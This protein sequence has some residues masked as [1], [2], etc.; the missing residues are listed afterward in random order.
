M[1][2]EASNQLCVAEQRLAKLKNEHSM[3]VED[4]TEPREG[5]DRADPREAEDR[6]K[7]GEG[8][9][10]AKP[11]EGE[12]RAKPGEGE[13][14]AEPR[15]GEDRAEPR[16]GE[17]AADDKGKR[18]ETRDPSTR[19]KTMDI[20][21]LI[22]AFFD[23]VTDSNKVL[24]KERQAGDGKTTK[25]SEVILK[26]L[27]TEI[28][29]FAV[30][31]RMLDD[32][33]ITTTDKN[34][35]QIDEKDEGEA[36][37][38]EV[39]TQIQDTK[40]TIER[41][42]A[43]MD[44]VTPLLPLLLRQIGSEKS[45]EMKEKAIS[46]KQTSDSVMSLLDTGIPAL[47]EEDVM[48]GVKATATAASTHS[49]LVLI[50]EQ[51]SQMKL[52]EIAHFGKNKGWAK[53]RA[54]R[55]LLG[56]KLGGKLGGEP[57][58]QGGL[59][60]IHELRQS[61]LRAHLQ[62]CLEASRKLVTGAGLPR[63]FPQAGDRAVG[64]ALCQDEQKE[65]EVYE[66]LAQEI[67]E[68]RVD[69]GCQ[70]NP[71][72]KGS[73]RSVPEVPRK[74]SRQLHPVSN[75]EFEVNLPRISRDAASGGSDLGGAK[76]GMTWDSV[77]AVFG[78]PTRRIHT[79]PHV[80]NIHC[81]SE[82]EGLSHLDEEEALEA[83]LWSL[84]KGEGEGAV[85]RWAHHRGFPRSGGEAGNAEDSDEEMDENT[86]R[87]LLEELRDIWEHSRAAVEECG[88]S[89][90]VLVLLQGL[91]AAT[92]RLAVC[93]ES[94]IEDSLPIS[95]SVVAPPLS[96]D[97]LEALRR[98]SVDAH[99]Q[100]QLSSSSTHSS[101][102]PLPTDDEASMAAAAAEAAAAVT[103]KDEVEAL[104]T[105]IDFVNFH[106]RILEDELQEARA[107]L[108]Q[109]EQSM[110]SHAGM[111]AELQAGVPLTV[112]EPELEK[113]ELLSNYVADRPS[114]QAILGPLTQSLWGILPPPE[115]SD[116]D[117]TSSD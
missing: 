31:T 100:A 67:G 74:W 111:L 66:A 103:L 50:A 15:E 112:P 64:F 12:D 96:P 110:Q 17:A 29:L 94:A 23:L 69:I 7:P 108:A 60:A 6:A 24:R 52:K 33:S 104:R 34:M 109:H 14:R 87:A 21:H 53:V 76:K 77:E 3:R 113:L 19:K 8:E 9:D 25:E 44:M 35:L 47:A 46:M 37:G 92:E 49:E 58:A 78:D 27:V 84:A 28:E 36:S 81:K 99:I 70:C 73:G 62:D 4:C 57:P 106:N 40:E 86:L 114:L 107:L 88:A 98:E 97:D 101:E 16:E 102:A 93:V 26:S 75:N 61:G 83:A 82:K 72:A 5:D 54:T 11:G 32:E 105:D 45:S 91:Q 56:G 2:V 90:A 51:Q 48:E 42:V 65:A 10:R 43:A 41:T 13:D 79:P 68:L 89:N 59:S 38:L 30:Q 95:L 22:D 63:G 55:A 20:V 39:N 116:S 115:L 85:G 80:H 1:A 18:G 117:Y 71:P